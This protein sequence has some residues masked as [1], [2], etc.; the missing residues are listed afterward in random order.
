MYRYKVE[1]VAFQY[2][3]LPQHVTTDNTTIAKICAEHYLAVVTSKNG[4]HGM[5]ADNPTFTISLLDGE[6]VV[7][8]YDITLQSP[9]VFTA[10]AI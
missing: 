5:F 2:N 9:P 3:P 8:T 10:T 4:A 7:A 1:G 6:D